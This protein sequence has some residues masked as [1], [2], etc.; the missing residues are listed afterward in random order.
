MFSSCVS[1]L[2]TPYMQGFVFDENKEPLKEVDICLNDECKKS[3]EKGY[4]TFKR[5]TYLEFIQIGGEAPPLFYNLKISK[6]NY[7][8][9]IIQYRSKYGGANVDIKMKYDSIVLRRN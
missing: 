7:K 3:D 2:K 8:D 1:R 9:T 5:K 4:F 6:I